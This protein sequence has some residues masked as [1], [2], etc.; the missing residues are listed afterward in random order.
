MIIPMYKYSFLIHHSDF[1]QFSSELKEKGLLHIIEKDVEPD[2]EIFDIVQKINELN[3]VRKI[4]SSYKDEDN[5]SSIEIPVEGSSLIELIKKKNSEIEDLKQHQQYL[6][7]ELKQLLPWGN[8][9]IKIIEKLKEAGINTRFFYCS[10]DK[11]DEKYK[12]QYSLEK[13][14]KLNGYVYFVLFDRD[15]VTIDFKAD[16][17]KLPDTSYNEVKEKLQK[18]NDFIH[19]LEADL[20]AL[21]LSGKEYIDNYEKE[22]EDVLNDANFNKNTIDKADSRIKLVEGWIPKTADEEF[23]TFADSLP[24][25]YMRSEY[26]EGDKPPILLK[27]N[28]FA[29]LFEPIGK[30]FSLP[31]YM[32]VDLTAFFAPFYFL[33]FG[34]CLGDAGYGLLFVILAT[35]AKFKVKKDFKPILSL[36]QWLGI[37]TVIFG[38]LTGTFFGVKLGNLNIEF[39]NQMKTFMGI[40]NKKELFLPDGK[41]FN[42]ALAFG[43]VQILL[44][45]ALKVANHIKSEGVK[46]SFAAMGW[47]IFFISIAVTGI[48][49]AVYG[50][51]SHAMWSVPHLIVIGIAAL[52]I[53]VFNHPK[54]NV[55]INIGAGLWDTYNMATGFAGDILSYIRLFALGLSS[56]ILGLVFNS[57]AFDLSPDFPVIGWI[58]T[59][60]I[61]VVGHGLNIFMSSLGSFVHPMRLTFVEFY[62]N[63]GFVGG[64]KDYKPYKKINK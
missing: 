8:F 41:M 10:D 60:L 36:I 27:N 20:N 2:S 30:M 7:K 62:K 42:L 64:G 19:R 53:F 16:E 49:D 25:Y 11:F 13:V 46:Y 55:F 23:K 21:S 52:G 51:N 43:F 40:D 18:S 5:K 12:L 45:M 58:V 9:D 39:F 54:R 28:R 56:G 6:E 33:F 14:N 47:F 3:R 15:N 38:M 4:M 50:E 63:A 31:S 61:L 1:T 37:A 35:I 44:G 26:T 17:I 57:L 34:F 32:E 22:L 29:R 59:F 48:I 24:V